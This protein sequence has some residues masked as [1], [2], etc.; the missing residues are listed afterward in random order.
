MSRLLARLRPTRPELVDAGFSFVLITLALW[1]FESAFGG[2]EFF[3]VGVIAAVVGVVTAHVCRKFDLSV[4][5]TVVVLLAVFVVI[6]G[7]LTAR[8]EAIAGFLPSPATAFAAVRTTVRGW[9][10]LLTTVPPVGRTGDLLVLPVF[11]GMF[12]GAAGY[13]LARVRSWNVVPALPAGAVMALGILCGTRVPVSILLHGGLMALGLIT[14]AAVRNHRERPSLDSGGA[15]AR[16][17]AAASALLAVAVFAGLALGGSLPFAQARDR[18]IWRDTFEPPFDPSLYP[19]PLGYYREYVKQLE[20]APLFTV[21]GLPEGVPIRMATLDVH[22]GI[23]WKVTGGTSARRGSAGYF[24]RVGTDVEPDF[25]DATTTV[26]IEFP[27][28]SAYD[29]VWLP[30]VGEAQSISFDDSGSR[31]RTLADGYRYNRTTDTAAVLGEPQP[32]DSYEMSVAIPPAFADLEPDAASGE[33]TME[34]IA[35][36]PGP[37]SGLGSGTIEDIE[38]L[39]RVQTLVDYLRDTGYYSDSNKEDGQAAVPAGHGFGRLQQFADASEL[40]GNAEQY[41]ATLGLILRNSGIP[42]RVVMGFVPKEYDPTGEVSITGT[43]AEAWVEVLVAEVGWVPVYPTPDRT[44]TTIVPDDPP[45]PIPDRETQVPPPPP[46]IQPDAEVDPASES[47]QTEREREEAPDDDE[48]TGG[49]LPVLVIA[50]AAAV[51]LPLLLIG[52]VIATIV[53]VKRRRRKRRRRDGRADERVSGGW[54]ELVD[55]A[56]D[57]GRSVPTATTRREAASAVGAESAPQLARRA[58]AAVFGPGDLSNDEI[59]AFWADVDEAQQSLRGEL[60]FVDRIKAA[61]SLE[62]FRRAKAE[63][64]TAERLTRQAE[65]Y[66]RRRSRHEVLPK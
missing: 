16:R 14:W 42:A 46:V 19:S 39:E 58:D 22:D 24:E 66:D 13:L 1:T 45:K 6:G 53:L 27:A 41:A 33:I 64:R 18:V 35:G 10:E 55:Y 48:S 21:T 52:G 25:G 23:V 12:A 3:L 56:V 29:E 7:V 38:G 5:V 43:D 37:V 9:K 60:G 63:R 15:R 26:D 8:S 32:G 44:K 20:D 54:N 65:R 36:I 11:C 2:T 4:I 47:T 31:A 59:D 49:G 57:A 50:G 40:V 51:M 34:E 17:L 30:T 61:A 62:S 28:D